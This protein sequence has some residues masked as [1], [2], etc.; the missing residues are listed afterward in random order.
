MARSRVTD[1]AMLSL[2]NSS[3]EEGVK[4]IK[5]AIARMQIQ[6]G[7]E[8]EQ[9]INNL[10][11][12]MQAVEKSLIHATNSGAYL[13]S[14]ERLAENVKKVAEILERPKPERWVVTPKRDEDGR[15]IEV[16]ADVQ[17]GVRD[18]GDLEELY[19]RIV[20]TVEKPK[21]EKWR[22]TPIRDGDGQIIE[23]VA[24]EI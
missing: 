17:T 18:S 6:S 21:P 5:K 23:V 15:I 8:T 1:R 16:I 22:I 14:V 11:T 10:R 12:G 2:L 13:A 4:Q 7:K 19:E 20:S 9:V 3:P 24:E